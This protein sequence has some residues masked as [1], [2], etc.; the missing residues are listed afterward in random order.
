M[1]RIVVPAIALLVPSAWGQAVQPAPIVTVFA[2][3]AERGIGDCDVNSVRT[4][5]NE[6]SALE[7][8][9]DT[10][11]TDGGA[12]D[13]SDP[14][15]DCSFCPLVDSNQTTCSSWMFS[16][17]GDPEGGQVM[18]VIA[19]VLGALMA[20]GIG[21]ND[22]ANALATSV[23]SGAIS[24]RTA[25]YMGAIGELLGAT[26]L[27][28]GVS[29]TIQRGVAD[30]KDN[31]CWGCGW[32]NSRMADYQ[33]GMMAAL[34]GSSFFLLLVTFWSLPVSTTHAV[35]GG[36]VGMT[37]AAVG[38]GC[39]NLSPVDGLG[40]IVAGWVVS[41]LIAGVLGSFTYVLT[42]FVIFKANDPKETA[43]KSVPFLY[44]FT[45]GTMVILIVTKASFFQDYLTTMGGYFSIVVTGVAAVITMIIA[46]LAFLPGLRKEVEEFERSME[47]EAATGAAAKKEPWKALSS[48]SAQ[49]ISMGSLLSKKAAPGGIEFGTPMKKEDMEG[50]DPDAPAAEEGMVLFKPCNPTR[51]QAIAKKVFK[52]LLIMN[53][54]LKCFA[55]GANDTSNATG[56]V[57]AIQFAYEE[58][59]H[60]C[61][62]RE[63]EW[64]IMALAGIFVG[65]GVILMGYRVI[66]AVG[67]ELASDIDFHLGFII[68][69]SSSAAVVIAT[70]IGLPVSTTHCQIGAIV[71]VGAT[72]YGS[73]SVSWGM[74]GKIA[75]T[76]LATLP[77]AGGV[78]YLITW[79][80]VG[81]RS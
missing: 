17:H 19:Y 59:I 11:L 73:D 39:L 20:F 75:V 35:V 43:L 64:W 72:A 52:N 36:V 51:E 57:G 38:W 50:G 55:H 32:C 33:F 61:S 77:A 79:F 4:E 5:S 6:G 47:E 58:G 25:C 76:W 9:P 45:V 60:A 41:P 24:L 48:L 40:F 42:Y 70:Y 2:A 23:G 22:S 21:G 31:E 8:I 30:L 18:L 78:G 71:L 10:I 67:G 53:A 65:L 46:Q 68:E 80:R 49:P 1:A 16:S 66:E 29:S 74:F 44:G 7:P 34:T 13:P 56:P 54:F 15:Q 26:F 63:T 81:L 37:A 69:F 14:V 62:N 12:C 3:D 28:A 27:G